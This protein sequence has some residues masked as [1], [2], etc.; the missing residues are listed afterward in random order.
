MRRDSKYQ[1]E[2]VI[3]WTT[4]LKYLQTVFKE[5]DLTAILNEEIQIWHFYNNLRLFIWAQSDKQ[6]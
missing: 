6:D 4:D 2:K 5:F 3:D 1:L